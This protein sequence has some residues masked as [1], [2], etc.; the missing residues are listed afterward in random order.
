MRFLADECCDAL[1][2]RTLRQLDYEVIYIAELAPGITD[3]AVLKRA[4]QEER[5]LITEDRDFGELVFRASKPS[6]GIIYVR[7]PPEDRLKK[8]DRISTLVHDHAEDLA[9]AMVTLTLNTI[10]IRRLPEQD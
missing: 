6:Y 7:I 1:I 5:I 8:A 4:Y 10:R 3:D 2:V 9:E